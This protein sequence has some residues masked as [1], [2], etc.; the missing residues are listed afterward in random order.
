MPSIAYKQIYS[1]FY[2]KVQAYDFIYREIADDTIEEFLQSWVHS[3]IAIPF[4][5]R[6]FKNVKLD[7][8]NC[9][10]TF[11]MDYSIDDDSDVEF[12]KEIMADEMVLGWLKPKIYSLNTIIQHFSNSEAK[13]Y[14]QSQHLEQL[15]NL[16][17]M[18]NSQIR[19]LVA[20][21]G[22]TNNI[23]LDGTSAASSLVK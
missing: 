20:D 6:L 7:D 12:V 18:L 9:D 23:Y 22:S 21:R 19:T 10:M 4:V 1:R 16:Y 13:F 14:S 17:N 5:R 2:T 15:T 3:S 8:V 11:E